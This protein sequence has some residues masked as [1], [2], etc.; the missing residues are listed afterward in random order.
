MIFEG[1]WQGPERS[2]RLIGED[3]DSYAKLSSKIL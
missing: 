1:N 3:Q 2:L